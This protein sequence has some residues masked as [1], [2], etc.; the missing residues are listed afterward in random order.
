M[1]KRVSFISVNYN[2]IAQTSDFIRSVQANVHSCPYEIIIVD[3]GS[4]NDEAA[5]LKLLFPSIKTIRSAENL[6]FA[7]GNNLALEYAVGDYLFF[8]ILKLP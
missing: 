2:G 7:G 1:K 6:G 4:R 5:A 8:I 3:N